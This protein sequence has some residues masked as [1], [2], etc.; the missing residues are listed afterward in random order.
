M[1]TKRQSKHIWSTIVK[2]QIVVHNLKHNNSSK[3]EKHLAVNELFQR[4]LNLPDIKIDDVKSMGNKPNSPLLV[5]LN[6][7]REKRKIYRNT[8]QLRGTNISVQEMMTKEQQNQRK[9][10]VEKMKILRNENDFAAI[11]GYTLVSGFGDNKK[12][13]FCKEGKIVQQI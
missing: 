5:T 8:I 6:D 11:H 13:Y 3:R 10:L 7:W 4:N 9:L 12:V 2:K 1:E